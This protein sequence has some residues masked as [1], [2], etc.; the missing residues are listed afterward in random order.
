MK[1]T[2]IAAAAGAL[3]VATPATALAASHAASATT[4][5][6]Q[7]SLTPSGKYALT[8]GAQYQSQPGQRELQVELEH[9][10]T[11]RGNSLVVSI[12]GAVVGSMR[13]ATN[14][15]AQLTRNTEL[16]QRVPAI[17]HGSTVTVKTSS[18]AAVT[19][20]RF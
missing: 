9:L 8:G 7:I 17:A 12:N 6:F 16:G 2:L 13:V 11:L 4:A 5:N 15:I 3:V 10:A 14:G 19:S 20:G 18:G 1:H